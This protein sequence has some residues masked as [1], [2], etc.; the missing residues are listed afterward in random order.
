MDIAF[1]KSLKLG[2]KIR[3]SGS[4]AYS[5][6]NWILVGPTFNKYTE[7]YIQGLKPID[8]IKFKELMNYIKD[9]YTCFGTSLV[10]ESTL[11]LF[12]GP[13]LVQ[14]CALFNGDVETIV[15][16]PMNG[17]EVKANGRFE[18]VLKR[19]NKRVLIIEAK[20]DDLL[21]GAAQNLI[22]LEVAAGTL[23]RLKFDP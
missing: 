5:S 7:S 21:Q 3:P 8:E 2:K 20:K 13:L 19:G 15:E 6:A 4:L 14:V 17:S 10:S 23:I 9:A 22:G 11:N 1:K 18:F 16:Q 12:I